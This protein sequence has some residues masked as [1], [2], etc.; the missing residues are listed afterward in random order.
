MLVALSPAAAG[1]PASPPKALEPGEWELRE[2]VS[3]GEKGEV[4]RVCLAELRQLIQLRHGRSQCKRLTVDEGAK[5][6]S[7]SYDCGSAGSGRTDLR[8]ETPR[9]VQI[10]TQ[11]IAD[12]APFSLTLE[13]R[14]LGACR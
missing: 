10:R 8:L 11:G 13:G 5:H 12:G 2:R 7:V 3:E 9:L 4:R 14:R 1:T 6:L